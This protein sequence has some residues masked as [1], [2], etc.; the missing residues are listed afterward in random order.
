MLFGCNGLRPKGIFWHTT[1]LPMKYL[2]S[3]LFFFLLLGCAQVPEKR[4][5]LGLPAP[6]AKNIVFILVDDLGWKDLG[7][8]GSSFY[9]TPHIDAMASRGYTFTNAYAASPVCSPTRAA[10][11][12]GRHPS[13]LQITD[14]I[15]G[16]DPKDR[17]LFGPE[18][19]D[20]LP[21]TEITLAE[22]LKG[23]GYTTFF[24]G[25]WHLGG[26]GHLPQNQGFDI[27]L[28]GNHHGQPP[29]GYYAPYDNPQLPDGP[30]GE[31][32][33]DRLTDEAL[34][35]LEQR[36]TTPFLLYLSYYTVHTP[37]QA[38]KRHLARF[39]EKRL[40]LADS[41]PQLMPEGQGHTVQNQ[42]NAAYA[43]MVFA[44]DENMGRLMA[45]L[46]ETGLDENTMVVFTSDNGG[47]TTLEGDRA[48]PTAVRPLRA[49]KGWAYEG[50]I[51]VPLII[52]LPQQKQPVTL[53]APVN[54]MDL[55]PTI[56][57]AV[58]Q[59]LRPQLHMDGVAL[60]P[61]LQGKVL[62]S[63]E[64]LFWDYPHYHGSAWTPGQALRQGDWKL[65]HFFE[66]DRYELYHL[67]TDSSETQNLALDRPELLMALKS[68]LAQWNARLETKAPKPRP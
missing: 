67:P 37:I 39:E 59:P 60:G 42:Y 43:S 17:F 1:Q 6:R 3:F 65:V 7:H 44:L 46:K 35:F 23:A 63:H 41:L 51:R 40:T 68:E 12:T 66:G 28:G 29:G 49:G 14:W 18:D 31:Y 26:E 11:L 62:Q 8:Y 55:F 13:R 53:T 15:P 34:K 48:A 30:P 22:V 5:P 56:L 24:A 58:G 21:L 27:N 52:S 47:L 45:K 25:K 20:H 50:G 33:T 54:S 2:P 10:L 57:E 9:E 19:R 16:D 32:L 64:S 4:D 38:S 61:L 36:S